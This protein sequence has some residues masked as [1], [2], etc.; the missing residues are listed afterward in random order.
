MTVTAS[1]TEAR[2]A[3]DLLAVNVTRDCVE[4]LLSTCDRRRAIDHADN[5]AILHCQHLERG[6][7]SREEAEGVAAHLGQA[8]AWLMDL[9]VH[10]VTM[11]RHAAAERAAF[12]LSLTGDHEAA[13]QL[14][15]FAAIEAM[16]R[17]EVEAIASMADEIEGVVAAALAPIAGSA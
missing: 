1:P 4:L 2:R 3:L 10:D 14:A 11:L 15:M 8:V 13:R 17:L 7:L 9:A 6:G 5:V 16:Q 12:L